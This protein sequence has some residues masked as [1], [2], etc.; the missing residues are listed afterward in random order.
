LK[1]NALAE[2]T[3]VTANQDIPL[4]D[5]KIRNE[6]T[7]I[8]VWLYQVPMSSRDSSISPSLRQNLCGCKCEGDYEVTT[9]VSR[10]LVAW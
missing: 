7:L 6:P 5:L 10:W 8:V 2:L 9:V 1:F 4:L 3:L